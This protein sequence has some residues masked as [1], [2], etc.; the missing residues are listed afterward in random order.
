[1]VML[2]EGVY[3]KGIHLKDFFKDKFKKL[4]AIRY[5]SK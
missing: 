5:Q 1:M 2:F 3:L 4:L